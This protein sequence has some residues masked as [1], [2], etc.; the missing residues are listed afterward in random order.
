MENQELANLFKKWIETLPEDAAQL[1][2]MIDDPKLPPA[3]RRV[4]I[5]ALNYLMMQI[6]LLPDWLPAMGTLDDAFVI[7]VAMS[8]VLDHEGDV[9]PIVGKLA[10]EADVVE[11]FIG[12]DLYAKFRTYVGDLATQE[13]RRRTPDSILSDPEQR[14]HFERE[15][16]ERL[17]EPRSSAIGDVDH[18]R[19]EVTS[20]F[21]AKLK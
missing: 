10:N 1:R 18:L 17:D 5:G 14:K 2:K 20:Y 7:R 12:K 15:L 11:G 16:Q 4:S 6:D 9:M 21:K 13:V 19:R 8:H 3:A